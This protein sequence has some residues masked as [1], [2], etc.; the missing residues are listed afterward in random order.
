[1]TKSEKLEAK[2]RIEQKYLKSLL[3]DKKMQIN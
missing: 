2:L 3:S 1:M